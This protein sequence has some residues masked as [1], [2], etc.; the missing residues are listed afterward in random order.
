MRTERHVLESGGGWPAVSHQA[1]VAPR[2][3]GLQARVCVAACQ[4]ECVQH[5]CVQE[6]VCVGLFGLLVLRDEPWLRDGWKVGKH[7]PYGSIIPLNKKTI[8]LLLY[9]NISPHPCYYKKVCVQQA[10]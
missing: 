7:F 3:V 6:S 4:T 8:I 9:H 2:S 10:R 5:R 1:H